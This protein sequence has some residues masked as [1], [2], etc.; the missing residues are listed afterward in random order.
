MHSA[1]G[2]TE[3]EII[4]ALPETRD[5]RLR[6]QFYRC[7]TPADAPDEYVVIARNLLD[8]FMWVGN[9]ERWYLFEDESRYGLYRENTYEELD[10]ED[11]AG[12]CAV[13]KPFSDNEIMLDLYRRFDLYPG[14]TVR[15]SEQMGLQS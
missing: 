15:T 4:R 10:R 9:S 7:W 3:E 8:V 13:A 11:V 6:F 1:I 14:R 2:A 5:E 12:A